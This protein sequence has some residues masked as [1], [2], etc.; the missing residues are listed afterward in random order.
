[1]QLR[2]E[3]LSKAFD[4]HT[5]L[6]SVSVSVPPCSAVAI[7]G[8]SG[9]GK[10]TLLRIVAG[11]L[12]PD[13]GKAEVDGQAVP[14]EAAALAA[15]RRRLGVVFQDYNLFPH[16]TAH[17]NITLPLTEVH[18]LGVEEANARAGKLLERF[19]LLRHAHKRPGALSGGQRQRVAIVRALAIQP[20]LFLFDEP[21]SALDPEMTVEVL[22]MIQSLKEEGARFLLVT[23]ELAFARA[24]A[25]RVV[26]LSEGRIE[27]AGPAAQ[28]F[29]APRHPACQ[30]F[31]ARILKY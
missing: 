30:R 5:V 21:T 6:H 23:H 16:L 26:F 19:G 27:E 1:M 11:L 13:S 31:I 25:D 24:V 15:Y 7:I 3:R 8:P 9:C 2:L 12:P 29:G 20:Q 22:E 17:R 4:G 14:R 28:V 10:S 18:G